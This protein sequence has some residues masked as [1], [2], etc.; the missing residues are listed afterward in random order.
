MQF[1]PERLNH[2]I[3]NAR[4]HGS[5]ASVAPLGDRASSTY[6]NARKIPRG[7]IKSQPSASRRTL[8][9]LNATS[10]V[11]SRA[12]FAIWIRKLRHRGFP[13]G[14]ATAAADALKVASTKLD[15]AVSKGVIHKNNAANKKSSMAKKVA[16]L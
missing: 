8:R 3:P 10:V 4:F 5:Q 2:G 13:P 16:S 1:R 9:H 6:P 15:K 12:S 11:L 7:N 14:D